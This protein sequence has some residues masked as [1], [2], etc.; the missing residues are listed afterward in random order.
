ME[1]Y[2][3]FLKEAR[4]IEHSSENTATSRRIIIIQIKNLDLSVNDA[5][6]YDLFKPYGRITSHR[7]YTSEGR[8]RKHGFVCYRYDEEAARAIRKLH[9]MTQKTLSVS[10]AKTREERR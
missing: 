3:K 9:G 8:S 5:K 1:T 7:I 6:L 4:V 10:L 2:K